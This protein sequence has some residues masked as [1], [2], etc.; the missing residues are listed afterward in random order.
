MG[1]FSGSFEGKINDFVGVCNRE[2]ITRYPILKAR[3]VKHWGEIVK[4]GD[5]LFEFL[6]D[7]RVVEIPTYITEN[8]CREKDVVRLQSF[9]C[10]HEESRDSLYPVLLCIGHRKS[11]FRCV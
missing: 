2:S 1:A 6:S 8:I 11:G 3:R 7:E 5:E 4:M 10:L 9:F